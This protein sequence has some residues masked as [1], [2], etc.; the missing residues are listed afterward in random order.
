METH[1]RKHLELKSDNN[2]R[3]K[4]KGGTDEDKTMELLRGV[5]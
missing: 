4:G 5:A 1:R 2:T 3:V